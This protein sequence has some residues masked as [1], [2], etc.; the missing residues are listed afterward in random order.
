MRLER[1]LLAILVRLKSLARG[2]RAAAELDEELQFH[3]ER[4]IEDS[5]AA[6]LEP[7]AARQAALR[8]FGGLQQRR[9]ECRELHRIRLWDALVQDVRYTGRTVQ[10]SRGFAVGVVAI[11]SLGIGA[12]TTVFSVVN[13][14]LIEPLPYPEPHRI[15]QILSSTPTETSA[16]ASVPRF[17]LW[18]G[19]THTFQQIAAWHAGGPGINVTSG[20][21]PE[22]VKAVHASW[23]YFPLFGGTPIV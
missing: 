13:E 12:S 5:M 9:E 21:R 14:V 20:D 23:E 2:R 11:L 10:R 17:V 3:I 1:W 22:H 6:G 18:R 16:L 15:V 8:K 19:A 4:Q 7:A